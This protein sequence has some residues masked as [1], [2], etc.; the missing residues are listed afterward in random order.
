MIESRFLALAA[1]L[2]L[3]GATGCASAPGGPAQM[4]SA[5]GE[6]AS[7]EVVCRRVHDVGSRLATRTCKT[8][9]QWDAEAEEAQDAMDRN[10]RNQSVD[11]FTPGFGG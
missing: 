10:N 8:R 6:S 2:S 7:D 11:P 3:L 5:D 4:A 9:E 1:A